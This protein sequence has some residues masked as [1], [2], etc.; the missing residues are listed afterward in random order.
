MIIL[1]STSERR[2]QILSLLRIP[3]QVISPLFKEESSHRLTPS[4]EALY[5]SVEKAKSVLQILS[6]SKKE[7]LG[8]SL[9]IGSD[10]LIEFEGKKI[11]K[12]SDAAHALEILKMLR[13]KTHRILTALAFLNPEKNSC[14]TYLEKVQIKMRNYSDQEAE[15]TIAQDQPFDKAGAYALQGRGRELT[16][17]LEG[18]YLAAIGLPLKAIA[19]FLIRQG[20][21]LPV[22]PEKIYRE[23][24]FM[25]WST[26]SL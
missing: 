15:N 13:G 7:P 26:Y 3:F 6:S 16:Q 21:S 12:P 17:K 4:Q 19:H 8:A 20:I 14:E 25:N 9:I 18:D 11:G 2:R 24:K 23:K 10:T 1:A 5:F 22:E